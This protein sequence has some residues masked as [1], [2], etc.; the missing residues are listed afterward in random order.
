MIRGAPVSGDIV[1]FDDQQ[2]IVK[3]FKLDPADALWTVLTMPEA[4]PNGIIQ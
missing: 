2:F 1:L 3:K 4:K